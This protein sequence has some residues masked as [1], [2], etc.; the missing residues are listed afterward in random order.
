MISAAHMKDLRAAVNA[1]RAFAGLPVKAFTDPS[2]ADVFPKVVHVT[3][4]RN[5]L[6]EARA[7]LGLPLG[8]YQRPEIGVLYDVFA[9]DLV[10]I[11]GG[12]R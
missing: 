7:R 6:A 12:V 2:L 10:E 8:S 1:V 5:A 9:N 3:E 11:R 4:L